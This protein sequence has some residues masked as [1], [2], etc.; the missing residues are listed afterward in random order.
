VNASLLKQEMGKISSGT[1][2]L[3][4]DMYRRKKSVMT[5]N[6]FQHRAAEWY[7]ACFAEAEQISPVERT[8]RFLEE[9][10]ELAQASNCSR[11]EA[12]ELVDYVFGRK[13]GD[14]KDEV[15]GVMVTLAILCEVLG[16]DMKKA[17]EVELGRNWRRI[18]AIR[19]KRK[20]KPIGSARPQ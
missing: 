17:G 7:R 2:A 16:W 10:L 3:G 9:A 15:G 14:A 20:S 18:A 19:E 1:F 8:H 4:W 12:I 13:P 11:E 6:D 5:E